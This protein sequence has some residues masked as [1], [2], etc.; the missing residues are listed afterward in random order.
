M[1]VV[2]SNHMPQAA[3]TFTRNPL[4]VTTT[5]VA[6]IRNPQ[7]AITKSTKDNS[8]QQEV[9]I[10]ETSLAVAIAGHTEAIVAAALDHIPWVITVEA[11]GNHHIVVEVFIIAQVATTGAEIEEDMLGIMVQ[12][13]AGVQIV[14]GVQVVAGVQAV[15]EAWSILG[16]QV[17]GMLVTT[18]FITAGVAVI[19]EAQSIRMP[20]A[21]GEAI[22]TWRAVEQQQFLVSSLA[23]WL[24]FPYSF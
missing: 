21:I 23:Q 1:A 15:A 24:A 18:A 10:L 5:E 12:V 7:V 4:V 22:T 6:S 17:K 11:E 8:W 20:Q 14:A 19:A 9:C 3:I 2:A 16:S 13:V